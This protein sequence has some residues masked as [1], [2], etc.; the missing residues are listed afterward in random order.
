V[1]SAINAGHV[2]HIYLPLVIQ[3]RHVPGRLSSTKTILIGRF[4][5]RD[6]TRLSSVAKKEESRQRDQKKEAPIFFACII[7]GSF[8]VLRGS[9]IFIESLP[10][11]ILKLLKYCD[12][13]FTIAI[14]RYHVFFAN[15][16]SFGHDVI[17][18]LIICKN[19]E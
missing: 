10:S 3:T 8:N 19:F 17:K 5:S 15:T 4:F 13:N 9:E 18:L 12:L 7:D 6:V 1:C 16:I 2:T 11:N 14:Y